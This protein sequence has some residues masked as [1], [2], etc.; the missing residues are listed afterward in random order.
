MFEDG[1]FMFGDITRRTF[2][3]IYFFIFKCINSLSVCGCF[4]VQILVCD[5]LFVSTKLVKKE[6]SPTMPN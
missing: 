2:A 5:E 1:I 4:Y 6:F 3:I